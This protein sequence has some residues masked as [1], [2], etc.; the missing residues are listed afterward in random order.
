ML[1]VSHGVS[2]Q[3]SRR[4]AH[5]AQPAAAPRAARLAYLGTHTGKFPFLGHEDQQAQLAAVLQGDGSD[6]AG[7]SAPHCHTSIELAMGKLC[8]HLKTKPLHPLLSLGFTICS[9]APQH[10]AVRFLGLVQ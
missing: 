10:T 5:T 1:K 9:H 6:A 8:P 3:N 7:A 2:G 4:A